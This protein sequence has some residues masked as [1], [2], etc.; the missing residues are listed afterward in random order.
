MKKNYF[1]LIEKY[2]I[3][4]IFFFVFFIFFFV[5][6]SQGQELKIKVFS[7]NNINAVS[8]S[9]SFGKYFIN[10]D[11]LKNYEV[12]KQ[13]KITVER[14][15]NKILLNIDDSIKLSCDTVNFFSNDIKCFFQVKPTSPNINARRYDNNLMVYLNNKTNNLDLINIVSEDNYIAGVV[16]S[17]AGGAS[18][19]VEFF[20]VQAICCRN[21]L[22]K[23]M[24]KHNKDS[25]NLCDGVN[26]QAYHSRANKK[27]VIEGANKSQGE[28]IVDSLNNVIETLFHSNSG[29]Q[30]VAAKDVWGK[31]ISYLQPVVDSFSINQPNY[32][33]EKRIREKDWLKYF[34]SKGIDVKDYNNKTELEN[35]SQEEG[36]KTTLLGIPLTQIRK[37]FNLKSTFFT[38]QPFGSDV[39]L[40]GKG[41]GHGVGMSQEGAAKMCDEGYEY[42]QVIEHYYKGVK[43]INLQEKQDKK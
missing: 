42:W 10:A 4:K 12:K 11:T 38:I 24:S 33:W 17:E 28:V 20:K 30:T 5:F 32:L 25:Y 31:D 39:K 8:L 9:S 23:N 22:V 29:G 41:Y 34:K 6:F 26:C 15:D 21:Y 36:R 27:E 18:N 35:F 43:I 37:D 2:F 7:E 16:Q 14:Q 40:N 13:D 1:T 19:N 3:K